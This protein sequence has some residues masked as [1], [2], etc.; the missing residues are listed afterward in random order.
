MTLSVL[1]G[2]SLI[3]G[4][5]K[6]YIFRFCGVS[7]GPLHLQSFLLSVLCTFEHLSDKK[8]KWFGF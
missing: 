5:F 6:C 8:L 7:R 3:A 1:E 2:N 4:L